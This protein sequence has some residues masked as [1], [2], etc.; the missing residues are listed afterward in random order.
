[1]AP[2]LRRLTCKETRESEKQTLEQTPAV[3]YADERPAVVR[4]INSNSTPEGK[5]QG[6]SLPPP[7]RRES[8]QLSDMPTLWSPPFP[9]IVDRTPHRR[10]E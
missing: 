5:G 6:R 2:R 9:S 10:P 7:V 3:F 8:I 1:M 4:Q